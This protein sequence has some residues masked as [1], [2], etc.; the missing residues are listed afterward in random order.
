METSKI[1]VSR[2]SSFL[3]CLKTYK[4]EL[5]GIFIGELKNGARVEIPVSIGNHTLRFIASGK[6]EEAV[7]IS[8][9]EN[10]G[11]VHI[12]ASISKVDGK[13]ELQSSDV[14]GINIGKI[15]S[16]KRKVAPLVFVIVAAVFAF[17]FLFAP[18][19]S[20]KTS[21]KESD[22]ANANVQTDEIDGV[23]DG[24]NKTDGENVQEDNVIY[25][26]DSFKITYL[27]MS[28]P[29]TGMTVFYMSLKLE[30]DSDKSVF[31]T[32]DDGYV[33]DTAVLFFGGNVDF[34][35]TLPGKKSICTF[36]FGYDKMGISKLEDIE[37][38]EFKIKLSNPDN[39]SEKI[40]ET[41]T[42]TINP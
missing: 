17:L 36:G 10:T 24:D 6:C 33:N 2:A 32:L 9:Y 1:I 3:S 13:I 20:N 41:D 30:N 25:A 14:Q 4:L 22:N 40:L 29:P 37:K 31:I 26:D 8:I 23:V 38:I 16:R 39:I 12:D 21:D 19:K 34:D 5:D 7:S 11:I 28:D 35:G 15:A 27:E 42:I 18:S